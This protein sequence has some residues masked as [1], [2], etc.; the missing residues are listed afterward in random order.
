LGPDN[1]IAPTLHQLVTE[2]GLPAELLRS[3]N[4]LISDMYSLHIPAFD[5]SPNNLVYGKSLFRDSSRFYMVDGYGDQDKLPDKQLCRFFN[6]K[7]L[8]KHIR[9]ISKRS[10]LVWDQAT[11]KICN[12]FR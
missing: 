3:L 6:N 4:E 7:S 9:K 2:N 11:R 8:D 12:P 1:R 10:G 5:F